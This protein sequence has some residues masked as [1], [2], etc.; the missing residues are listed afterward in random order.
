[1][2]Q[3]VTDLA[4]SLTPAAVAVGLLALVGWVAGRQR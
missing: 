1:V 2:L 3:L 4:L